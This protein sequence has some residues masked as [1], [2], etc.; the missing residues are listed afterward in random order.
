MAYYTPS[1]LGSTERSSQFSERQSLRNCLLEVRDDKNLRED[2]VEHDALSV[3]CGENSP[4][5]VAVTFAGWT[6]MP[7]NNTFFP[8]NHPEI[9]RSSSN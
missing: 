9:D 6:K 4:S 3:H 2:E 7:L 8:R 5:S 1:F